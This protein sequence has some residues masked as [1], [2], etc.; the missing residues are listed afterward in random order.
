MLADIFYY[1]YLVSNNFLVL[2]LFIIIIIFTIIN[3]TWRKLQLQ[4]Q[5]I[6]NMWAPFSTRGNLKDGFK[7][8]INCHA[9]EWFFGSII[10]RPSG[11]NSVK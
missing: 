8:Y 11:M 7:T 10:E 3:Q 9:T 1:F 4:A 2:I 6:F 5:K